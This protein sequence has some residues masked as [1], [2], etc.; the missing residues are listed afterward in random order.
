MEQISMLDENRHIENALE[1]LKTF[2]PE[3]GYWLA[4]SGGK[5]S[6]VIHKLVELAN[7]K[8]EAHYNVTGIDPPELIYFM[9]ENYK[10]VSFD[11]YEKSMWR[12]IEEKLM[13]P[14]R[15]VRYCCSEL[16]ERGGMNRFIITGVRWAES[17][18][19]KKT[20]GAIENFHSNK[21]YRILANDND[22]GRMLLENCMKKCKFILNPIIDWTD[23]QVWGFIHKYN[24]KYCS[25]YD[26]GYKRL[27]C[28]G[29]PLIGATKQKKE[30]ERYPKFKQLYLKAFDKML[31]NRHK[32]NK[33]TEWKTSEEVYNW[34][35]EM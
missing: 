16:K 34:W 32:K 19:R 6:I 26:E 9:R 1:R 3:E 21:K 15:L 5:D 24:L 12:L 29:C 22:E 17:N 14:T 18:R 30:F 20:R 11:M 35:V 28:I 13:P 8:F 33:K 2:E 7:V 31:I 25:L 27:G 4:F 10:N 23:N